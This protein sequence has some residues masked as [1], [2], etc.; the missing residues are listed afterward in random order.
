MGDTIKF[1]TDG[2]R[3]VI[4][5]DFNFHNVAR[6]AEGLSGFLKRH[7]KKPTGSVIIGYDCR[8]LSDEAAGI[9]A[10]WLHEQGHKV[11]LATR[12]I[13]T[14][15]LSY[16]VK[17]HGADAGLM[18]TASHNP[19]LYNGIKFKGSYGGSF[20]ETLISQVP[21]HVPEMSPLTG[22]SPYAWLKQTLPS[23]RREDLGQLYLD[24]LLSFVKIESLHGYSFVVDPMHG[25]G[26]GYLR[27]ALEKLGATVHEIRGE[28]NP[29]FGGVHPEPLDGTTQELRHTVV[30][31]QAH[32]GF[33]LDGDADR[34]GA[35][36]ENGDFVDSHR[37]FSMLLQHLVEN[38]G[39]KGKVM[40]TVS[41]TDLI[42]AL[43]KRY[44]LPLA[45][46]PVG[47]KHICD[48]ML[49]PE[50][51][52][53]GGEESGGI[54]FSSY[55]PERDGALCALLLAEMI[56]MKRGKGLAQF[57]DALMREHGPHCFRRLDLPTPPG[58]SVSTVDALRAKPPTDVQG[59]KVIAV[60]A[61]DGLKL[62][63]DGGW[64]MWR[65]SGTEPLMRLYAEAR[66]GAEAESLIAAGVEAAHTRMHS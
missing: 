41:T 31:R 12:P 18:I 34:I 39:E 47:F 11:V 64:L 10:C 3:G 1:G 9:A 36:D 56:A 44:G 57:V 40:K 4:G 37:I 20:T 2:W 17:Q 27:L 55:L 46:T 25:A 19:A 59:R 54:G 22:K 32:A 48:I 53:M 16:A 5:E 45:V 49:R 60:D 43:C 7:L 42:D 51:T 52:L 15:A 30:E 61:Q 13:P 21:P 14:P 24:K 50:P 26:A 29:L 38:R 62:R 23:I 33:I 65:G 28:R 6:V 66:T 35:R 8:F 58:K 63:F